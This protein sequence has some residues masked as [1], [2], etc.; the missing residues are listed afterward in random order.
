MSNNENVIDCNGQ[1]N[2]LFE[3]V[4][5]L[6]T[7][8]KL[9]ATKVWGRISSVEKD[10]SS[11]SESYKEIRYWKNDLNNKI[12]HLEEKISEQR[13]EQVIVKNTVS[14]I[15]KT[16]TEFIEKHEKDAP[17]AINTMR[18]LIGVVIFVAGSIIGFIAYQNNTIIKLQ[19]KNTNLIMEKVNSHNKVRIK[20][21]K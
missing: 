17:K 9:N 18:A 14:N 10:I 11:L 2:S 15:D 7:E 21:E 1:I 4:D 5:G 20:D 3:V 13:E 6:K 8:Y 16:M 12:G 19:E